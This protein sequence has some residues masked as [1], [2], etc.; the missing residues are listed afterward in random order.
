MKRTA[1]GQ[2]VDLEVNESAVAH[3][4]A[5]GF[6]PEFG[7][8]ELRR[9]IRTELETELA[10]DML[11]NEVSEGDKVTAR[12]DGERKKIVL[13]RREAPAIAPEKAEPKRAPSATKGS[14]QRPAAAA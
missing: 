5:A 1:H 9:L 2:G 8:R 14:R 10:R 13:E 12:W 6:R 11:G 4:A 7:A 3:L